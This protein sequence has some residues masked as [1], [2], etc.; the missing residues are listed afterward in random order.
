MHLT[1]IIRLKEKVATFSGFTVAERDFI[2]HAINFAIEAARSHVSDDGH[3]AGRTRAGND[4][5]GM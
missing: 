3:A 1:A 4:I 5:G 2:L